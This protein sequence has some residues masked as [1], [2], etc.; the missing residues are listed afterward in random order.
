VSGFK[1]TPKETTAENFQRIL[2]GELDNIISHCDSNPEK[3]HKSIHEIRKC[4][5]K[6]RAILRLVRDEIGY[7]TY[8]RENAFYRD[9]GRSLSQIRSYNV[10]IETS[11]ILQS[12]LSSSI[13]ENKIEPLIN[14]IQIRRDK[15]LEILFLQA[16]FIVDISKQAVEAKKRIADYSVEHDDFRAFKGGLI[17]IYKQGMRYRDLARVQPS[18]HNLHDLRKRMKYLWYQ[19][20]ILQP[21][22]PSM[23]EAYAET[24]GSIGENLGIY[25]DFSELQLYLERNTGI[26]EDSINDTLAEGCEFKKISI[27]NRTW[28][29]IDAI[30]SEKPKAIA[31]RFTNY[32]ETYRNE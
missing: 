17:R 18:Y 21:I 6:I 5:K 11:R 25:H 24:L 2:A 26:I 31:D 19:M 9:M 32:W 13:P 22:F 3:I 4:I 12:D 20:L 30:Y 1:L 14:S 15:F 8:Y 27:L 29:S 7:S 23:L 16:N 10:L 28:N